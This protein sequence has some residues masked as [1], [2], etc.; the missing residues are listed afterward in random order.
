MFLD[1]RIV[2][3]QTQFNKLTS[4]LLESEQQ[5]KT[6]K[7]TLTFLEVTNKP[8]S[9]NYPSYTNVLKFKST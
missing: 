1:I 3:A 8:K 9:S 5:T 2:K 7:L 4:N 6:N